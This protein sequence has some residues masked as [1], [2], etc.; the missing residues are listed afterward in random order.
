LTNTIILKAFTMINDTLGS[1]QGG[2]SCYGD[3][4]IFDKLL[5]RSRVCRGVLRNPLL[6]YIFTNIAKS[7][8]G[9][10]EYVGGDR[11]GSGKVS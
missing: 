11:K 8:E 7:R 3:D 4:Q 6:V 2:C 5:L 10:D 1:G 9:G